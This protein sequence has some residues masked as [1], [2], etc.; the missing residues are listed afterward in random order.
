MSEKQA[1]NTPMPN[2]PRNFRVHSAKRATPM[3]RCVC[4][5]RTAQY[6]M[7]SRQAMYE[8]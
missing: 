5:T 8:K 7:S 4:T 3:L 6:G 2:N 1:I